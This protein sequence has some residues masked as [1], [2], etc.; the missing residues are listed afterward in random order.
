MLFMCIYKFGAAKRNEIIKRR[1]EREGPFLKK[2]SPLANGLFQV[3][4]KASS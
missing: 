3:E 1:L 2:P 4:A